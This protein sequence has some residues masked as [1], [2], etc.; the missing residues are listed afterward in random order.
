[1]R[2]GAHR[3]SKFFFIDIGHDA[4]FDGLY[5]PEI[6]ISDGATSNRKMVKIRNGKKIFSKKIARIVV[7]ISIPVALF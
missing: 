3:E 4:V 6:K 2:T 5:E 7:S 1:M